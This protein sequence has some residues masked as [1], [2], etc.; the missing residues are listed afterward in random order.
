MY[1]YEYMLHIR[2]GSDYNLKLMS[3][4]YFENHDFPT[5]DHHLHS[6]FRVK[7]KKQNCQSPPK[8]IKLQDN[9]IATEQIAP[10]SHDIWMFTA[11]C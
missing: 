1:S 6:I 11:N 3:L 10:F 5:T 8:V 4:G 2:S 7:K 9:F